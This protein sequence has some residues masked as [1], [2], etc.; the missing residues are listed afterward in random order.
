MEHK[1][2]S[3]EEEYFLKLDAERIK[4]MRAR[5]DAERAQVERKSHYMRCPKCGGTLKET[6]FEHIKVD[7][8]PDCSGIWFD[9]GEVEMLGFVKSHNTGNFLKG[10]FKGLSSR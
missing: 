8:C 9:A 4:E 10:L 2:S 6:N 3:N 5:L 1:P 7:V